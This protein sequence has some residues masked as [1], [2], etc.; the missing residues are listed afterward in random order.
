MK[1]SEQVAQ[2]EEANAAKDAEIAELKQ[3]NKELDSGF[4]STKEHLDR[5]QKKLTAVEESPLQA[6]I[7]ALEA[8]VKD[9]N[10]KKV[11]QQN[12]RLQAKVSQLESDLQKERNKPALEVK[13]AETER[14]LNRRKAD[15]DGYV[16]SEKRAQDDASAARK[17]AAEVQVKLTKA[18]RDLASARDTISGQK[19]LIE[20]LKGAKEEEA[21]AS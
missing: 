14:E 2:M 6:Q 9:L 5:V 12:T 15:Q 11:K 1:L 8:Q 13:L 7:D 17:E 3:A 19:G 18:E 21:K 10:E 16:R 4:R 20:E